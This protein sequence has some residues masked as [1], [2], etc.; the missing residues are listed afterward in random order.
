MKTFTAIPKRGVVWSRFLSLA[1]LCGS[2]GVSSAATVTFNGLVGANGT[3]WT[4]PYTEGTFTVIQN[5]GNWFEAHQFGNPI[6]DIFGTSPVASVKVTDNS[7]GLFQ[8]T[9]V[10]LADAGSG[11]ATY[12]ILGQRNGSTLFTISD[13]P[14]AGSTFTT[15]ANPNP[16]QVIDTLV[17]S[18]TAGVVSYNIDNIVMQEVPEPSLWAMGAA[19]AAIMIPGRRRWR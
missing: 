18:M 15:V 6:P 17:I 12:S 8:F 1:G 5:S 16:A 14:L 19:A 10:D 9:K 7:T 11:G 3:P 2:L 13:G 4:T